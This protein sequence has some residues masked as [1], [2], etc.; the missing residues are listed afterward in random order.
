MSGKRFELTRSLGVIRESAWKIRAL[1]HLFEYYD[2]DSEPPDPNQVWAGIS[3]ILDGC[4]R[5]LQR[6]AR[7]IEENSLQKAQEK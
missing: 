2:A 6:Q 3:L 4:S 1:S 7:L 5:S